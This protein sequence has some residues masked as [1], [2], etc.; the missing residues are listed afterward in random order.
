[1][2]C[3]VPIVV[4]AKLGLHARF[5]TVCDTL[6]SCVP[7][8]TSIISYCV[9]NYIVLCVNNRFGIFYTTV[10]CYILNVVCSFCVIHIL[11][12]YRQ[13]V[14]GAK[15]RLV[16]LGLICAM[17]P[18]KCPGC[19][20][21]LVYL[22]LICAMFLSKRPGCQKRLV[23]LGLI[24]AMFP[25]KRPGCQKRFDRCLPKYISIPFKKYWVRFYYLRSL[26]V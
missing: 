9:P 23:Y 21:C 15:K 4:C 26:S 6:M 19:Q 20:K 14:L 13:I 2:L 18:S 16:Y 1:M 10:L 25:S 24:C 22:G 7:N 8:V 3:A 5:I 11:P 12:C 17:F